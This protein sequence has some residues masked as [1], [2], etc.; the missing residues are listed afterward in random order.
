MEN[1]M[2]VYKA[3][4][5][6]GQA[7]VSMAQSVKNNKS[8]RKQDAVVLEEQLRYIRAACR[9]KAYGEITRISV[10]EIDKTLQRITQKNFSGNTLDMSMALLNMQYQ[11]LCQNIQTYMMD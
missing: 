5:T 8:V 3:V 2:T 9:A 10:D 7:I 1:E 11:A 6:A 4:K